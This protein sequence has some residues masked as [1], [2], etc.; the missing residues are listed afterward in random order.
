[1]TELTCKKEKGKKLNVKK[2]HL[3]R[4]GKLNFEVRA[5]VGFQKIKEVFFIT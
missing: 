1:M 5:N 4:L 3:F 2:C